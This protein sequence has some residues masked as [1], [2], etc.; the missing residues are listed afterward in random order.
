MVARC[1]KSNAV[2]IEYYVGKYH[3]I[4]HAFAS[5]SSFI[6]HDNFNFMFEEVAYSFICIYR[7]LHL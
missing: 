5:L 2:S 3:S 4:S 7:L 6:W 1:E